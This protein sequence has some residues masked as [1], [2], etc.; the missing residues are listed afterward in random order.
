MILTGGWLIDQRP[1][2]VV[3]PKYYYYYYYYY[4]ILMKS[5]TQENASPR[6]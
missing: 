1:Q 2:W 3:E 4:E 5:P 6:N